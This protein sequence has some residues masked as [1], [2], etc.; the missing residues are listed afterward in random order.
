MCSSHAVS[1]VDAQEIG[2]GPACRMGGKRIAQLLG[3]GDL[4]RALIS[5]FPSGLDDQAEAGTT[6]AVGRIVVRDSR[7]RASE[8]RDLDVR[9]R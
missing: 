9:P 8:M 3:P 5:A 2:I 6:V 7:N 1:L 4:R